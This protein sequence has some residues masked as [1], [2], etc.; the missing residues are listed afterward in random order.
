[1][2]FKLFLNIHYL[3]TNDFRAAVVLRT[4]SFMTTTI[5]LSFSLLLYA[6]LSVLNFFEVRRTIIFEIFGS[7]EGVL[8]F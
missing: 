5:S 2:H 7:Q 4:N 6:V 3:P 8:R 1:M